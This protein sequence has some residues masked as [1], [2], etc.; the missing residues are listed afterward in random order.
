[1]FGLGPT[2][3]VVILALA[4]I[5]FGPNKLVEITKTLSKVIAD[6]RKA[7]NEAKETINQSLKQTME[8]EKDKRQE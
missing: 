6:F 7:S 2:E 5:I 1:M 8:E 4:L 3:L